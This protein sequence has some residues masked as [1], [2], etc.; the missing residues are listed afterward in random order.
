MCSL[1]SPA[2]SAYVLVVTE[3]SLEMY[4]IGLVKPQNS[5]KSRISGLVRGTSWNKAVVVGTES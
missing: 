2:L 1:T 3:K 5:V 4:L